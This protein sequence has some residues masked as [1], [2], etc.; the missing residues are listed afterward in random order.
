M[1]TANVKKCG[2]VLT[3]ELSSYEAEAFQRYLTSE[4][5]W[6]DYP[7]MTAVGEAIIDAL[8]ATDIDDA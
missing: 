5:L 3:V 4:G 2:V 8:D 7:G 1:A 6:D